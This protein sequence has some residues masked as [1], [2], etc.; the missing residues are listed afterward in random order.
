[1]I[2]INSGE[3]FE[4]NF[5]EIDK[6]LS[7]GEKDAEYW[8]ILIIKK[9]LEELGFNLNGINENYFKELNSLFEEDDDLDIDNINNLIKIDDKTNLEQFMKDIKLF[10]KNKK[11]YHISKLD[12]ISFIKNDKINK[13]TLEQLNLNLFFL[14]TNKKFPGNEKKIELIFNYLSKEI[15]KTWKLAKIMELIEEDKL[16]T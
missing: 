8:N 11:F 4:I 15:N 12:I 9:N 7:G 13:I 10:L 14:V 16:I 2:E 5:D 1:M 6:M 3:I